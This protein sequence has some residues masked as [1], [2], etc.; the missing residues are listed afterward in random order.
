MASNDASDS[1]KQLDSLIYGKKT[2]NFGRLS[3]KTSDHASSNN[4]HEEMSP[5]KIENQQEN[6]SSGG[7]DEQ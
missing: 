6:D 7:A 4:R 2:L 5:V 3:S 1:A